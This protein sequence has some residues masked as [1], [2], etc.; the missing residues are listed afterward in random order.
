MQVTDQKPKAQ[1]QEE[2]KMACDQISTQNL[3]YS[4]TLNILRCKYCKNE[5]KFD[6]T[7][8]K[9]L[10]NKHRIYE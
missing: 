4:G 8:R 9:I 10:C 3:L 1:G 5:G 6:R 7:L 2:T